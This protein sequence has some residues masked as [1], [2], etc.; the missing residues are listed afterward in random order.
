[1]KMVGQRANVGLAEF[2]VAAED[3][4]SQLALAQEAAQEDSP[5]AGTYLGL[6][7]RFNHPTK[8]TQPMTGSQPKARLGWVRGSLVLVWC[9]ERVGADDTIVI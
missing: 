6:L 4:G 7:P 2:A 1:M 8:A 5:P 9:W 3:F